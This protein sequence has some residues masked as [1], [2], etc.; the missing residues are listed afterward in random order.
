[1]KVFLCKN[2]YED[3]MSCIYDTWVEA[4]K[5]GHDQVRIERESAYI[6]NLF[7]EYVFVKTDPEKAQKVTK[8][9]QSKISGLAYI[10]IYRAA[11]SVAEDAPD[12]IYRFMILGFRIGPTITNMLIDP[13]V[14][15]MMEINRRIGSEQHQF[16][17]F[18]RFNSI[19]NQ[20]YISH[21][22]P[23]NNVVE[24]VAAHFADRMPSEYFII[25]DDKRKLAVVHP[26][27][28]ENYLQLLSEDEFERLSQ[29][30]TYEDE[31]SSMWRTFFD[32][33]AIKQRE[34]PRCQ[35]N[36]FPKWLR[37]HATEFVG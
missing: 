36:H 27:D 1:M 28:E 12:T 24:L 5:I 37:K 31:F 10:W 17:E 18:A 15:K 35:M 8:S 32:A 33:I 30:E 13:T 2:G 9:I 22:E 21:I 25:I 7:D 19:N 11:M 29:T 6:P 3:I 20:V 23:K 26:K 4:L 34:N 16:I 14:M